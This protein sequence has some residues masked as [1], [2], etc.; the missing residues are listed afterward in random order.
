[1][2]GATWNGSICFDPLVPP[3]G[4]LTATNCEIL[5]NQSTCLTFLNWDTGNL[6]ANPTEVTTPTSSTDPTTITVSALTSATNVPYPVEYDLFGR[7]FFL[8][9]NSVQLDMANATASCE[10]LTGWDTTLSKCMKYSLTYDE[11]DL[12]DTVTGVPPTVLTYIPG[13]AITISDK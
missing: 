1:V 3:S 13:A 10:N 8:Y 9:H 11:N 6:T 4:V 12:D 7:N 5:E 2:A